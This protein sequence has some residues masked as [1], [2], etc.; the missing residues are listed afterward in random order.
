[1]ER[2][3]EALCV[4]PVDSI[5]LLSLRTRGQHLPEDSTLAELGIENDEEVALSH[6]KNGARLEVLVPALRQR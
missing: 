1:M 6:L 2:A 3:V 5:R 4:Q